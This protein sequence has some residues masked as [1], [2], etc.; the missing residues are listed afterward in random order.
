MNRSIRHRAIGAAFATLLLALAMPSQAA[1]IHLVADLSG[2][3]EVSGGDPDGTGFADIFI[4]DEALTI[5][6]TITVSNIDEPVALAHIHQAPAGVD[7][8]VVVDFN[9]Q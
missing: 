4:D 3:N 6:W 1:V 5:S 9:G 7:G 2:A 8:P